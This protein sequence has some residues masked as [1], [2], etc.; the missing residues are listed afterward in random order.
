MAIVGFS[1]TRILA[2]KQS[3]IRGKVD[4]N[5]NVGLVAVEDTDIS[6]AQGKKGVRVKFQFQSRFEPGVGQIRLEGDVILLEDAK[7]AEDLLKEWKKSQA[8]PQPV[9][10]PV[11]NHILDR[12]NIQ[13]LILA[14]DISL[15]APV[16]LPKVNVQQG[17]VKKVSPAEAKKIAKK[18]AKPKKK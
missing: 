14:R 7:V 6:M 10:A 5:N 9:L 12:S 11:L 2:E 17:G 15:P 8:L 16:P 18:T 13:A 1:F 4:I 3:A